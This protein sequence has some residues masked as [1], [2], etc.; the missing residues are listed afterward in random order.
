MSRFRVSHERRQDAD[1]V[2]L[3]DSRSGAAA[4]VWPGFGNNCIA[5]RVPAPD[6]HLV[7][8]LLAPESLEQVREQ[9]SWWGVPLL[10]PWPGRIPRGEYTFDGQ[11]YQLPVLDSQGNAG[12]GFVKTRPWKVE[13]ERGSDDAASVRCSIASAD[14]PETLEGYPFPYKL[15]ATYLLQEGG[16]RLDVEVENLGDGPM[17]FG[18]GPHPYFRIPLSPQGQRAECLVHVPAAR[19][20]NLGR[21]GELR[22]GARLTWQDVAEPVTPEQDRRTPQPLGDANYDGGTTGLTVR[23]ER[24]ECYVRDPAASLDAVMQASGN[25]P[26]VV[27]YTPPGRPGIC[28]EPWTC[29]PNAFN[30]AALGVDPSGV[31]V[32]NPGERWRGW[33]RL[34]LRRSADASA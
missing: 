7:E 20:W 26:T 30:L 24:I 29:P 9:P 28:F 16:L 34:F 15:T 5:A 2:V 31:I 13:E 14:H 1:L 17:P 22:P 25:F 10:F 11:R 4:R 32:L 8:L 23:D 19:R 6:G 18:F 3:E 33:M 21:I 12:H 27:T